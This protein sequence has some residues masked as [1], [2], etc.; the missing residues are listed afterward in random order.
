MYRISVYDYFS[1]A[2]QLKGYEGKC[3]EIHGHNWKVE[4]E[5]EGKG[6]DTIG[7]LIDFKD[8]KNILKDVIDELDHKMLN[9]IEAFKDINPSSELIARFIHNRIKGELP[10][11]V[12][13]L[14]TSVWE[15]ENS[16]AIY[17]E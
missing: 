3:E 2:H 14:S 6:L 5:V 8:L 7:M 1:S 13:I 16:K 4:I 9:D 12:D 11:G 15:S 17:F 10:P